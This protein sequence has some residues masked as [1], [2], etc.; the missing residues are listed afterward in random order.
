MPNHEIDPSAVHHLFEAQ[1]ERTPEADA[2]IF[3]QER[4]SYGEL[5][6]RANRLARHL[7]AM[8]VVPETLV[9]ILAERSPEMVA[10][11]LATLK[12]GG[13][14]VPLDPGYPAERLGFMWA[15]VGRGSPAGRPP[16]LLAQRRLA[17]ALSE[18]G[19]RTVFLDDEVAGHP[20]R[21]LAGRAHPDSLAYVI[22]TSGS[23]GRPKGVLV[24]HRGVVNVIRESERLL[25]VGP[26]DRVLQ[27][28]S[29]GFDA[30]A[31]EIFTALATG[32]CLVLTRRE[33]LMSGE[34]LGRELRDRSIT[35]MA[36]PPSLLDTV[37]DLDLPSLRSI[38]VGGEACS[39]AT[40]ARWAAGRRLVNAYAPT[41]ATIYATAALLTGDG[42]ATP[43]IG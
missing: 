32:A 24:P 17:D 16:V 21:N 42:A 25:G 14:Y 8:G 40:A 35:T 34:A 26:G 29:L 23:T 11:V 10:G 41:E 18:D 27:L 37:P 3:E 30:S 19:G 38:I 36:I 1:A 9:G 12:A 31:L 28:A 22:Y 33:T 13:A 43:P 15:D 4:L 5:N 7:R 39:A 6:D 2:L 20:A